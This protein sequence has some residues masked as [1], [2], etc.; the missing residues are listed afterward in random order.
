MESI[1]TFIIH[2]S[3]EQE[4]VYQVYDLVFLPE[5]NVHQISNSL[6]ILSYLW[7][8]IFT[9]HFLG[10]YIFIHKLSTSSLGSGTNSPVNLEQPSIGFVVAQLFTVETRPHSTFGG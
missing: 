6:A 5:V 9:I 2:F 3:P 10:D 8:N 1:D 4:S 7:F